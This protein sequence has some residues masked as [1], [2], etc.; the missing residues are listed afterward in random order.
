VCAKITSIEGELSRR[1][2]HYVDGSGH[3]YHYSTSV[4]FWAFLLDKLIFLSLS[5]ERPRT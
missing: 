5:S 4:H 2:R 3:P 1:L